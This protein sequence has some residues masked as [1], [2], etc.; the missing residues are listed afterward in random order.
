M[1]FG[2]MFCC[3]LVWNKCIHSNQIGRKLC[4]G[5]QKTADVCVY[6]WVQR[7]SGVPHDASETLSHLIQVK[8]CFKRSLPKNGVKSS[9]AEGRDQKGEKEA[10]L[11]FKK[12]SV[13]Q[14][15]FLPACHQRD[16]T[17]LDSKQSPK[18]DCSFLATLRHP[19]PSTLPVHSF[20]FPLYLRLS[21]IFPPP[22]LS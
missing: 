19:P 14:H 1:F 3:K 18:R 9:S 21:P 2:R 10:P 22:S 4:R 5:I 20:P 17:T 12:E 6:H 16:W 15:R 13:L 7:C 8:W 11:L